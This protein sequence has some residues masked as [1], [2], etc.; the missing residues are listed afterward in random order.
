[1]KKEV[2]DVAASV[3]QRLQNVAKKANRPFQEVLEN[4]GM[5]RFLY[6][7]N[8]WAALTRYTGEGFLEIDNNIAERERK[9]VA[10][11]RKNWLFVGSEQGGKTAA[12]MFSFTSTCT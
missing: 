9:R 10:I 1:M 5:E 8:N 12:V 3:R 2:K 4:F 6:A 11:S 7:L